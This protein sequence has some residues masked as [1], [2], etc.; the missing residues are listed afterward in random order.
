MKNFE[1]QLME[2][3]ADMVD[4]CLEYVEDDAEK[5]YI[6]CSDEDGMTSAGY[7]YKLNGQ[8]VDRHLLNT[9]ST[10]KQYDVSPDLQ[11][12]VVDVLLEDIMK[13]KSLCEKYKRPMPTEMK[14]I[15]DAQT[16]RL[17]V[18]YKYDLQFSNTEDLL[19][20]DLECAWMQEL[21]RLE[22]KV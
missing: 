22:N 7:F 15:Y 3:Q 18:D 2:L 20:D 16:R 8:V 21:S 6:Y 12:E 4:I 11:S 14:M 19:P 13:I 1:D 9:V 10:G 17:D 5:V